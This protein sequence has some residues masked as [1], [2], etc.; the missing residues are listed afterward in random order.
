MSVLDNPDALKRVK[1]H[2]LARG[3]FGKWLESIQMNK[4]QASKFIKISSE[5]STS[6]NF[7][8]NVL[9]E[10]AT[11]P[12]EERDKSQQLSGTPVLCVC[13]H[14]PKGVGKIQITD[15]KICDTIIIRVKYS[16][17][18]VYYDGTK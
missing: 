11:M 16:S 14:T 17:M 1:E 13:K 8:V 9:Y 4:S 7:G 2:D 10:I 12:E 5:F 15:G 6:K 3:A 18:G